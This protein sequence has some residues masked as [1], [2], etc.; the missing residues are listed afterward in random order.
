MN[1]NKKIIGVLIGLLILLVGTVSLANSERDIGLFANKVCSFENVSVDAKIELY[2][3]GYLRAGDT[4]KIT[5]SSWF[6]EDSKLGFSLKNTKTGGAV[7][8]VIKSGGK[9]S[10]TVGQSGYY[11]L[12]LTNLGPFTVEA[13]SIN[14]SY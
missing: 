1:K 6:P 4:F 3:L 5:S 13:G 8:E 7:G 2:D 10:G 14:I 11:V 12:V 9:M